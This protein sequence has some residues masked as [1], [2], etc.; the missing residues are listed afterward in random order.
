MCMPWRRAGRSAGS[1]WRFLALSEF[2]LWSDG[3]VLGVVVT[4][5]VVV[6][7]FVL[8][9][10]S[11]VVFGFSFVLWAFGV[12]VFREIFVGCIV[13]LIVG[14]SCRFSVRYGFGAVPAVFEMLLGG[15]PNCENVDATRMCPWG[16][17]HPRLPVVASICCRV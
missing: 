17:G 12:N 15:S 9:V 2:V 8:L 4:D 10:F 5:V 3:G 11:G 1:S 7:V 14:D 16:L 13:D 6:E